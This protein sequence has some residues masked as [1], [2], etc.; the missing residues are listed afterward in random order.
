MVWGNLV[1]I[2]TKQYLMLG[3]LKKVLILNVLCLVEGRG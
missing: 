3:K 1:G 2:Y